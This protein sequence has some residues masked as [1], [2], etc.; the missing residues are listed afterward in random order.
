MM[1]APAI[2]KRTG[3]HMSLGFAAS[4]EP[5]SGKFSAS[6]QTSPVRGTLA[7]MD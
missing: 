5:C 7:D 1:P 2:N 3:V 6:R 4:H